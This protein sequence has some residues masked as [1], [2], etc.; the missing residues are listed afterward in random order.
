MSGRRGYVPVDPPGR[1]TDLTAPTPPAVQSLASGTTS[2]SATW[3]HPGAPA[4]TTYT[5]AVRGS[6]GSTPTASGSGLGAWTWT[7]ANGTAYAATLTASASGQESRSDALVNVG[8]APALSWAA[9]ASAV[10]T[11]GTTSATIT[12]ATPTGGTTPYTYSA[13]SVV[14]DSTGASSTAALS[15]S[16][17][18][19]G[20]T[21]VSGLV[22]GQTVVVQ[23]TVTDDDGTEFPVQG[24]VTVAATSASVT[25]G[26]APAAQSLAAGTTSVTIG[27]WGSPSGGTGPYTYAVTELGGSGVTIG[28][29]G[30]GPWTAVG[31]T[32]GVTYAF[33][34]TVTDSLSAKGYSVVTVSVAP[35][36][37]IGG[38]EVVDSVDFT[39]SNWTAASTTSTTASTT[40]W[41]LTLYA[42]DGVT[43]RAY[44]RN[45]NTETR[46]LSLSPSGSGL[47]LV[48]G[49]TT[50]APTVAVWPAGW[51]ALRGGSRRDAWMVEAVLES[52]EPTGSAAFTHAAGITTASTAVSTP[53]VGVRV[54]NSGSNLL[55]SAYSYIGGF[56]TTS[57]RTVT[58]GVTRI[59]RW[60]QQCT[61]ADFRRH[62]VL[63]TEGATDYRDPLTGLRVRTQATSTAIT[64][65]GAEVTTSSAWGGSAI[66]DR[67]AFALYH[68]GSAT[69][70]SA[71][72]LRKLRL[73]R[74]PLGSL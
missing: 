6:D 71:L 22:N 7:V 50:Q 19:A 52:E 16:G 66:G 34:L 23:R 28:G 47:T 65:V 27:T 26:T 32:D 17:A 5:C 46:T 36:A 61:V 68:D 74:K 40:A 51:D 12:W 4:G 60:S 39:D 57:V 49:G 18:G 48:N 53:A 10:V 8:E 35:S 43:P 21:T 25:A 37:A 33:L 1:V 3:T 14:Y 42:A 62:D 24:V 56:S 69:S 64:S 20:A 13:A 9:P 73:L 67:T 29:S 11:A 44:V 63:V 55:L 2:A 59:A 70:G 15:T 72:R 38:W 30:L 54:T 58:A 41:Y 45:N 31:L